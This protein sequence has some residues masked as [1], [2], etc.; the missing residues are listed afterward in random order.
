MNFTNAEMDQMVATLGKYL[1]RSDIVGYAAAR[2]TRILE[3][4]MT[5]YLQIKRD[6]IQKY[7][8]PVI[9]EDGNETG[10]I[11]LDVKS[12]KFKDFLTDIHEYAE[13]EHEPAL[14]LLDYEKAIGILT[15]SE[16]L[17]LDWMFVDKE[18]GGTE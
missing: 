9:D 6:L 11:W 4:E 2:N 13:I 12:P 14:M 3:S 10:D 8:E 18:M 1:D 16:L 15:G 7:G 5:E 17:E